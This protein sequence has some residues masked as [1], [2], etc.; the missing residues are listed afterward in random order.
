[1]ILLILHAW[2][3]LKK[4]L[5]TI[6]LVQIDTIAS[7]SYCWF[8]DTQTMLISVPT[9]PKGA[10]LNLV[11]GTLWVGHDHQQYSSRLCH[12]HNAQLILRGQ[13]CAPPPTY[14]YNTTINTR[15]Q[16]RNNPC[17]HVAFKSNC[18]VPSKSRNPDTSD[19]G[20]FFSHSSVVGLSP[21]RAVGGL[22]KSENCHEAINCSTLSLKFNNKYV[23][24]KT[25]DIVCLFVV[26]SGHT[27]PFHWLTCL[28]ITTFK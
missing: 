15:I 5:D 9:H 4:M 27:Q 3:M 20:M 21:R 19:Q 18:A 16:G 8:I 28:N 6:L 17:F 2:K 13:K 23:S 24:W 12:L 7:H 22:K 11:M 26:A 10:L 25:S 14:H 1:M